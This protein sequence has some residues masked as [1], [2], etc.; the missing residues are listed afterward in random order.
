[1]NLN[2][3]SWI[4][5]ISDTDTPCDGIKWSK[6]AMRDLYSMRGQPPRGIQ[7]HARCRRK[8][9]FALKATKRARAF[10]SAAASGNYCREH[11]SME[12][13]DHEPERRRYMAWLDKQEG[14]S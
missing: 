9:K 1:M 8:A 12:I 7:P 13:Y 3:P 4:K 6:V 5:P 14:Q 11:M 2:L 10:E